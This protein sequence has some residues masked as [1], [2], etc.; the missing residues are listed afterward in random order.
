MI[1]LLY[2]AIMILVTFGLI[3]LGYRLFGLAGL[4]A[5]AALALV[6]ADIQVL[7]RVEILGLAATLGNVV[8]STTFLITDIVSEI[9][10]KAK[11]KIAVGIGFF[12]MLVFLVLS[13]LTLAF[14]PSAGDW[15]HPHLVALLSLIPRITIASLVAY[16]ISNTHDVWAYQVWRKKF[17]SIRHIWIRNNASTILS[18][19]LDTAVF[20]LIAFLGVFPFS[21]VIQIALSTYIFKVIVAV[22]DTPFVYLARWMHDNDK[23]G[24]LLL[25]EEKD[26]DVSFTLQPG[27]V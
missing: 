5:F 13:Q 4:Y 9:Y 11:A 22:A 20:S 12:S 10:G 16:L 7:K 3:L 1:N 19:L 25:P 17:P 2:W 8:F 27:K 14:I 26:A 21:V 23:V 15:A 6:I 18:Q 24:L